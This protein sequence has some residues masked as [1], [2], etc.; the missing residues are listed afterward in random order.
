M[1]LVLAAIAALAGT[2]ASAAAAAPSAP[3]EEKRLLRLS[4]P[5]MFKLAEAATREGDVATANSI[6]AALERNPDSDVRAEARFQIAKAMMSANQT[7]DAAVMLRRILDEKP[8]ATGVRLELARQLQLLG[9]SDGALRELRAAQA[10]G[11]PPA[12]ARM[13]DRYSDALRAARPS[14]ASFEVALAPDSNI[15]RATRSDTLG[16]IFGD[17]EIGE[18]S[19][20]KS[21]L[22][23]SLRGQAYRRVPLGG[24]GHNLLARVGASGDLYARPDFNDIAGDIAIGPE[25]R[26]GSTRLNVE[27]GLT[28]RWFG[29]KPFVR[30]ARLGATVS[31]RVGSRSQLRLSG[32]ASAI[33]NKLNDLQDGRGYS[34]RADFE[35]ALSATSGIGFN[36]GL[37]RQQLED[38]GYSTKGWRAG[39][40]GWHDLGRTTLTAQADVGRLRADERLLLFPDKRSDRYARLSFAATLRQFTFHGFAPVARF[41]IERNHSSIEFYDYRRTRTELA[42]TRAF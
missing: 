26:F 5:Q 13:I 21:G 3:T 17:F 4:V 37:D 27:A 23:V 24:S 7:R 15:N 22:G 20:P 11:L 42:L 39:V 10:A 28:Q 41:T 36:L 2:A 12:V 1:T 18:D 31:R 30:V 38:P 32:T 25:F 29:Q 6:Y 16:T 19:K 9:D 40:L 34:G 35:H 8:A 14:G 33:D